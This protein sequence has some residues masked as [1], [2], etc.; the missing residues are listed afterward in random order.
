VGGTAILG[1]A[2]P[3]DRDAGRPMRL[4]VLDEPGGSNLPDP[5]YE[6]EYGED[7]AH[8]TRREFLRQAAA[9]QSSEENS[10]PE[11]QVNRQR[12]P[13]NAVNSSKMYIVL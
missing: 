11:P 5:K 9:Q 7:A 2:S 1:G 8:A 4:V 12:Q 6:Q 3:V 10:R 13:V